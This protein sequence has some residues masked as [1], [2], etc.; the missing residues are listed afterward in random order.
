MNRNEELQELRSNIKG[1]PNSN[2]N[3]HIKYTPTNRQH[4][5]LHNHPD[6]FKDFTFQPSRDKSTINSKKYFHL[7]FITLFE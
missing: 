1:L 3:Q 6:K 4:H 5:N 2:I 7:E